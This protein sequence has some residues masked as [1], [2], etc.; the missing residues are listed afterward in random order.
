MYLGTSCLID[1]RKHHK[2]GEFIDPKG[3]GCFECGAP[4]HFKKDCPKLKNKDRGNGSAQGWVYAV[5]NAEKKGN[6]SRDPDSNVITEYMAKG[7]QIFLAQISAKKEEDKSEGTKLKDVP[8]VRDFSE[9]FPE[10]LPGLPPARPELSEQ[11]QELSDKGFIRPS[12]SP[13]GAPVLFVKK[14]DGSFSMCIDYRELNKLTVKNRYPLPRIDNL[15][16]QLQGSNIYSKI[17][18]R[19]GYHQ[20]RVR[21]QDI[22]KMAFRTRYGHYKFQVMPFELTNAP[23]VFMDL[24]NRVCKPYLDKFIIVFIDDILIYSK[25]KTEHKEHLKEI[26]ELLKKE[27][28][29]AKFSKCEFWISKVQ[30][31]GHVI[32][33]RG[34]HVDPAKIEYIKDWASPK[35]PTE[36]HQ[37]LGL[38]GYYR[39]FNEGFSK[40]AK[41]MTKLTQKGIKFDWGEKEENAF[42]LIK[43]KLCSLPI[44]A[45]PEGSEDFVVY[46]NA[47]H[48]G[49]GDVLMQREKEVIKNGNEVLRRTVR[50]VEHEYKPTTAEE[51]QDRRNEMKARATLLMA[52]PNKDQLKFYSYQ[53]AKYLIES[54]EKRYRGN[55][56]SKKYSSKWKTHA[57]IWRNKVEIETISL[58]DLYNNLKIYELELTGSSSTSQ[59]TAHRV[60]TTHT[61]G[62]KLD[63]NGQRVSFDKSK[64]ECYNCHKHGYF[65][66]ECRQDG[67]V[68]YV[69]GYKL[70]KKQP[71]PVL[72][73][74]TSS[75]SSSSSDSELIR[76]I[77]TCDNSLY[78]GY[79]SVPSPLL[80]NFIPRKPNLTFIDKFVESDILD[81]TTI[82]TPCNAKTVEN[83]GVS[84]RKL[85]T[86]GATVNI[87]R[88][89]NT[90][91]TKAVNTVRSVNIVASKP[92]VN[93]PRTKTNAFKRGYSQSSRPFNRLFANK[94]SIVNKNVN[95][96]WGNPQ[97]KEYKEKAVIDSG[98]SRHMT[99]NKCYLDEYKDYN[100]GFVSFGYGKG[101]F[102]VKKNQLDHKVKVIRSDNGTEFKNSI[103]N[104]FCEMKGIKREFSVA[105]TPQQNGVAE[106]KNRTLIEAARTMLV[107]SKLPTTFWA[108]AVNTACYVL[109]RVLVI[110]PHNKTP[111]ELIRGRPPLIDFM[112]PFGCPVTILNTRDHL[113]KFD[114]KADEGYFVGYSVVS[115][116]MRV[117]NKRTRI[118]EE[119][120]NIIFLENTTNVKGNG[121]DCFLIGQDNIVAGQAQKEKEPEQE[122][123][124]IPLCT[125]DPLI[126]Q[127]P[128]DY[129]GDAGMK[130]TDVDE[131]E[132]S[133]KSGKHDQEARSESE[134]LNQREMQTEP[135]NSS[136]GIN[137]VST[138][139]STTGPSF[140]TDVPSTPVS[141]ANESE[142]QLFERFSPFKN[143]FT[144]PPVP[145]ISLMDNTGIFGNAY[146]DEDVE[147]DVDMNNV[148]SS[149][150]VHDTSFTKFHKDHPEDQV[151]G[152]LKTPVQTRHMTKI[153]EEHGLF[154]SVHKLRRINHKDFHNCLFACLLSQMEPKKPIQALKDPSWAIGTKWVFRN[155]KDERV[156]VVKNKA[157]LV[158][159]GH[160]QEEGID[161]DEVFAPVARIEAIRLFLAYASFKDFVVYQMDVKSAFL[162]GKIEEEVYVCQPLGFEDP[163][164]PDK[165]YKVEKALYGLHQAP[166]A[167]YETLSTYLLDNG[168][169]R[170]QIDKTLFIK[171]HKDDILLVQ[172]YVDDII[173]GSTK[174]EMSIEFEK[175]MHD[176]FQMSSM[177]ELSFFLGLQ[178]KQKS[179]GIFISQDKYVVEILKKFDFASIKTASTPMETN[180]ALIKDEKAEDVDVH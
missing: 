45:L 156:I 106:R 63:I 150:S 163:H 100:G 28:L 134:R 96:V 144:L 52:L 129:E 26:L 22:P 55:K 127:G 168:F 89:V 57:L 3:N 118:V 74:F 151:I 43:Q 179:D 142:E 51:K 124:L 141:T 18:L 6:A 16:D 162:Y 176:K 92:I 39:R 135:T 115:K 137:T 4:R 75:G 83:K 93:H 155:K 35:T 78:K 114:G 112:K 145:N 103:M 128:K 104:Q 7:C 152:S 82:V 159:Q 47:S 80:R 14:K 165:V 66:R 120:L 77:K 54:I 95:T 20:L 64:V 17:D 61:Q 60:S 8:I 34:I 85:S 50:T 49:L 174:K 91:N 58:D 30:F 81:V 149:Y 117:F 37:F 19:S 65:A 158:A 105:R 67:L 27:K 147:E 56:E 139:V 119:T 71:K 132:A 44:L 157:R 48:K 140:D 121:P 136:N 167:W 161:Y 98:C 180:K 171:R 172:V 108:E 73:A 111:Y 146:D 94:N 166:R 41:S 123:I 79:Q 109:N 76:V 33:S 13:W 2:V 133:D 131:N 88:P 84:T 87:V 25:D 10:D 11:L 99:G 107:D 122:Y 42:H 24:M 164:F 148:I 153:T 23:A 102:L 21:E 177:G 178:V 38:V 31:L 12:S 90:A 62:R 110:K 36:I 170:G 86:A 173:F 69:G 113:G 15:F 154:S 59:N 46:C 1:L 32:D 9:V 160:T 68:G 29:Y 70:K 116:A 169:H 143:A 125:T 101:K 72:M 175:L 40:I 130:P 97:Q 5:R 53:D 126:S 138:P